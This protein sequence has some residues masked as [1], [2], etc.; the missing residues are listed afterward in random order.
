MLLDDTVHIVLNIGS[1]DQTELSTLTHSLAVEV[2]ARF[3]VLLEPTLL[4]E[5]GKLLD[6]NVI[7]LGVMLVADRVKIDFR[8][9]DMIK[10]L[11]VTLALL[12][13]LLRREHIVRT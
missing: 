6:G 7:D 4:L 13:C 3:A 2:V 10:R 5:L 1:Y 12:K 11:L 9:D 8:F